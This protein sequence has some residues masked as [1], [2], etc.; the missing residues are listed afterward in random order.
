M[1]LATTGTNSSALFVALSLR[2]RRVIRNRPMKRLIHT[3]R[4]FDDALKP[5]AAGYFAKRCDIGFL[6]DVGVLEEVQKATASMAGAVLEENDDD[7]ARVETESPLPR[8][9]RTRKAPNALIR[10]RQD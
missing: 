2:R 1:N 10:A 5:T 8:V 6:V 7:F 9:D 3:R 4:R